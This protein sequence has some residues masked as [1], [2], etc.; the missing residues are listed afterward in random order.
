MWTSADSSCRL[1]RGSETPPRFRDDS[2]NPRATVAELPKEEFSVFLYCSKEW[3]AKAAF[4]KYS[5]TGYVCTGKWGISVTLSYLAT[6]VRAAGP[7]RAEASAPGSFL[8]LLWLPWQCWA[9]FPRPS[10]QNIVLPYLIPT[11]TY[12]VLGKQMIKP[13]SA[14][15]YLPQLQCCFDTQLLFAV[16]S[17][18]QNQMC[19]PWQVQL[20]SLQSRLS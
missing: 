11:E 15:E 4:C 17:L 12:V 1:H 19:F 16:V 10:R 13:E 5:P 2:S 7:C 14:A 9:A 6:G 18:C 3:E 20:L 8:P